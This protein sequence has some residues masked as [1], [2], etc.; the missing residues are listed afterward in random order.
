MSPSSVRRGPAILIVLLLL[1]AALV[2]ACG[3]TGPADL[4]DL[5]VSVDNRSGAPVK[6]GASVSGEG[7]GGDGDTTIDPNGG[8]EL[9]SRLAPTWEVTVAGRHLLAS[10]ERP[11]LLVVPGQP[12]RDL[13]IEVIVA[14]DGGVSLKSVRFVPAARPAEG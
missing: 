3:A 11:D 7:I 12:R 14:P 2:E 6:I 8:G 5:R 9:I 1:V 13:L 4:G 10:S